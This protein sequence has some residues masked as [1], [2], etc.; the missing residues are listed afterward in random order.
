MSNLINFNHYKKVSRHS[1]AKSFGQEDLLLDL[2][3]YRNAHSK[4][5]S[6]SKQ[7]T[8][9]IRPLNLHAKEDLRGMGSLFSGSNTNLRS[10][11]KLKN[12]KIFDVLK[13]PAK[14]Y[15]LLQT[16]ET[17]P[18][19]RNFLNSLQ[20]L[21]SLKLDLE[22]NSEIIKDKIPVSEKILGLYYFLN[23][24]MNEGTE[25]R[26]TD[27]I[28]KLLKEYCGIFRD[29]LRNLCD[30]S[31]EEAV[32][33][34]LIWRLII[35]IIDD[36][37]L[38][39]E[40]VVNTNFYKTNIEVSELTNKYEQE[41]ADQKKNLEAMVIA[42][43]LQIS[44]QSKTIKF[45]KQ[46]NYKYDKSLKEKENIISELLEP[47]S[48][49]AS[50]QEMR[51]ALKKLS[52]Y[53][54]E[55]E[56]EQIK[57]VN[58]LRD[59]SK[60]MSA[61]EE[62]NKSPITSST[63][64]QTDWIVT[65]TSLPQLKVPIISLH[66]FIP[67]YHIEQAQL[68]NSTHAELL[69]ICENSLNSTEEPLDYYQQVLFNIVNEYKVKENIAGAVIQLVE[70][71]KTP[72]NSS[73]KLYKKLLRLDVSN[74]ISLEPIAIHLNKLLVPIADGKHINLIKILDFI[75]K[76]TEKLQNV[77]E[78]ILENLKYFNNEGLENK[79]SALVS[80]LYLACL[81]S[82]TIETLPEK[83]N[84]QEFKNNLKTSIG[85]IVSQNDIEFF[86]QHLDDQDFANCISDAAA[87]TSAVKVEKNEFILM[88]LEEV[89]KKINKTVLEQ[90]KLWQESSFYK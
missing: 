87:K 35:K 11:V 58:T 62:T 85:W 61:A 63:Q 29:M 42:L 5:A 60:I 81:K 12:N 7:N 77:F 2:K 13:S 65:Q 56:N 44:D 37:L 84:S 50:C 22:L 16:S 52:S 72:A 49:Y 69:Q 55:S 68:P 57:Q 47:E 48:N 82:K 88:F 89:Q 78:N 40:S 54:S 51:L 90:E 59:L 75:H 1:A 15:Q 70:V 21:S 66:P 83:I 18:N 27:D 71:L 53:I 8:P 36:S 10:K 73:E 80:R 79:F 24:R 86:I 45:L 28:S 14:K 64:A 76:H 67:F 39:Q 33:L 32:I 6:P 25:I 23:D 17:L 26:N 74:N 41:I 4:R 46:E 31:F 9:S 43:K 3:S 38:L 20:F 34:E 19:L 30:K